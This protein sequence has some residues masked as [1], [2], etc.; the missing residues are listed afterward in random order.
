MATDEG[1]PAEMTKR[2]RYTAD[3]KAKV[4]LEAIREEL[5]LAE[6]AKKYE[7]HPTMISGGKRAAIENIA[8]AFGGRASAEPPISEVVLGFRPVF[9]RN[10]L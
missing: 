6:L 3:F 5:T 4:A 7:V 1:L 10:K 9:R 8:S 2:K